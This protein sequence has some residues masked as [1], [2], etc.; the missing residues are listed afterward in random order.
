MKMM[1][2]MKLFQMFI[3]GV[4]GPDKVVCDLGRK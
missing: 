2:M 3:G 1:M 4:S